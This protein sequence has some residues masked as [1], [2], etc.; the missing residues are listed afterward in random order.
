MKRSAALATLS[1]DHHR[2]LTVAS[3]LRRTPDDG[4]ARSVELLREFWR[5]HALPHFA[6]EEQVLL[7]ALAGEHAWDEACA[8]VL[9]EHERM[10][11][12]AA[13]LLAGGVHDAAACRRLGELLHEHVRFEE[14]HLFAFAERLMSD[15]ELER[16][17]RAVAE[18]EAGD[19]SP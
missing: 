7:P 18:A 5:Q 2:A 11:S 13:A 3:K 9:D 19:S 6:V 8:R 12:E 1:R 10:R 16:L 4:A 15:D 14:R 17:G